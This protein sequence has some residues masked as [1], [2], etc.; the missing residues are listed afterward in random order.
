[1]FTYTNRAVR[2]TCKVFSNNRIV[3]HACKVFFNTTQKYFTII[4]GQEK[5][6]K[7]QNKHLKLEGSFECN[8]FIYALV[9]TVNLNTLKVQMQPLP[10]PV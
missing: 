5:D 10:S 4:L 8:T 2:H 1:M 3:M 9:K 7:W 6:F